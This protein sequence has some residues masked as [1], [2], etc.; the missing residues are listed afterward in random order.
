[1]NQSIAFIICTESGYLERMSVM[2]AKTLRTYGGKLKDAPIYSYAPRIGKNISSRTGKQFESLHVIHQYI[3]L[4]QEFKHYAV[5]NKVFAL[6]HAEANLNYDILVFA[7]SDKLI[8]SEPADLLLSPE[9]SVALTAVGSRGIGIRSEKDAEFDYWQQIYEFCNVKEIS[10]TTTTID[11]QRI[12]GYW[13]SGLVAARTKHQFF[14]QWEN[15]FLKV[16][17]KGIYPKNGVYHT[18]QSTLSAT[19]MAN[20]TRYV[21]LPKNYNYPIHRQAILSPSQ[22]IEKLGDIA[23][24][25]YH[26]LFRKNGKYSDAPPLADFLNSDP[27]QYQWLMEHLNLYGVYNSNYPKRVSSNMYWWVANKMQRIQERLHF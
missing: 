11:A 18:D 23:T 5:A 21:E 15:N 19:L 26:D 16:L 10:Y 20:K 4:N 6:S 27:E 17:R 25:H 9:D 7:D 14:T 12:Q 13:N 24:A 22:K 2:F 1:M 8:L 3:P